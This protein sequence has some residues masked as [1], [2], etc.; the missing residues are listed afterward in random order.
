MSKKAVLRATLLA[1]ALSLPLGSASAKDWIDK[2][3]LAKDSLDLIPVQVL[4]NANGYTKLKATNHTFSLRLFARAKKGKRIAAGAVG[5]YDGVQVGALSGKR[6]GRNLSH[7]DVGAGKLRQLKRTFY[8]KVPIRKVNW[9]G[10][11]A[12]HRCNTLLQQKMA[13]GMSKQQVLAK[14]WMVEADVF[15]QFQAVAARPKTAV[16]L[17][18]NNHYNNLKQSTRERKSAPYRVK[19]QCLGNGRLNSG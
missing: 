11:S 14:N 4:S 16:K 10:A 13:K 9:W 8:F 2:V 7:K 5:A 12:I 3:D 1:A 15:F 19:V 17:D 6:W 18:L